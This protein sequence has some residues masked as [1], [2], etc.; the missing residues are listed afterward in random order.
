MFLKDNLKPTKAKHIFYLV[1]T[2]VLGVLLSMFIHAG[3]EMWYLSWS[4]KFGK[5]VI[6]YGGCALHPVVQIGLWLIGA[7]GGFLLGITW[8]RKIY[9]E[10]IWSKKK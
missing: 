3:I 9:I 6:W 4:D 2:T 8:W 1:F 5:I 7:V 10:K